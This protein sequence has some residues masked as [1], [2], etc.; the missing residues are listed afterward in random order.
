L[1]DIAEKA[2]NFALKFGAEYADI[3]IEKFYRTSLLYINDRF[4][5]ASSGVEQGL[6]IRVISAGAWGFASTNSYKT[7]EIENVVKKA[8]KM[9]KATSKGLKKKV[10]LS[11]VKTSKDHV[12]TPVKQPLTNIE[13]EQKMRL[14]TEAVKTARSF[15]PKIVSIRASY[16]DACGQ[17]CIV[18]SEG[19]QVTLE[20]SRTASAF[21]V[22]AKE[23]EKVTQGYEP[24]TGTA[25]WEIYEKTDA[26]EKAR[27]AAE[28]AV[29]ML[30]AKPAP[31]GR[32]TAVVDPILGGVF[33]HEAVGH[34]CE[35]DYVATK[36][37]ILS[38]KLG[39]QIGSTHV[40]IYDDSTYP[41]GWGSSKYDA[42]G[43]QTEKRLLIEKGILKN[44]ILD[45]ESAAKLNLKPNG[46][47]RAQSF[48]FRPIVRMSNT[49]IAPGDFEDEELFE[50]V[51]Y[52]I[53][54]KGS[55]GG[56][57]DTAKGTFLFAAEEAF[58]IEKGEISTPLLNASLSGLTLETLLNIDA[59][60]KKISFHP[61]S[62]GKEDQSVPAGDGSPH[63]R[64]RN[65]VF[66]GVV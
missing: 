45:R 65:V 17:Q 60:G 61:G 40:N 16:G 28:K 48:A 15:S 37:S 6:G 58:L 42:E 51:K 14:I 30:R 46:G 52:G 13:L 33:A 38:D 50:D 34:A 53:Y 36:Q 35:G 27:K 64:I 25:G 22:T 32:F 23:G 12:L 9:A 39:K 43:T 19:T 8:V 44:Y 59:V 47:A 55:L 29:N 57:V 41:D 24:L 49:Y 3:R 1:I 2:L 26:N 5:Q 63:L 20:P 11:P 56:Q 18:T 4:E 62:C 21:M 66:G 31:S 7:P 10:V 54:V